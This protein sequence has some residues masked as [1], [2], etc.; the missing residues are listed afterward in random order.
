MLEAD[1]AVLGEG[2]QDLRFQQVPKCDPNA[3]CV[4]PTLGDSTLNGIINFQ[5]CLKGRMEPHM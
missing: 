4:V 2:F 1:S 5:R 3:E